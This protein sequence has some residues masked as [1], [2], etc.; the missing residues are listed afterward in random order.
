MFFNNTSGSGGGAVG[1][2]GDE[3]TITIERSYFEYDKAS[4][5]GGALEFSIDNSTISLNDCTFI[6]NSMADGG[7]VV[8][9]G[10]NV[11]ISHSESQQI[12]YK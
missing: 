12:S 8:V 2:I 11:A 4:Y 6:E 9:A 10:S 7:A 3:S 1:V 5:Y